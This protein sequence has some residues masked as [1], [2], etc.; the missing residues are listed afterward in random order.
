MKIIE[1]KYSKNQEGHYSPGVISNG[2]LYVSG[3]LPIDFETGEIEA[4][5]IKSETKKALENVDYV[6]KLAEITRN[7][8]VKCNI[9]ISDVNYWLKVNEVYKEFFKEHKPARIVVPSNTLHR[10]C[11]VEIEV[12]AEVKEV[13]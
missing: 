3:Q 12:I 6:L 1:S 9:Y 2:M 11:L 5:G 10:G 13:I 7:E 8:V 4:G